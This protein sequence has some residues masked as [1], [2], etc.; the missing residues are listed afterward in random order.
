LKQARRSFYTICESPCD[1]VVAAG[2]QY[3]VSGD[4][5]RPSRR[6]ALP[7]GAHRDTIVV[8]P[9]SSLA[10][11]AGI[12]LTAVGVAAAVLGALRLVLSGFAENPDGSSNE[13]GR[14][15]TL[16][17]MLGGMAGVGGGVALIVLNASTKVSQTG[18]PTAGIADRLLRATAWRGDRPVQRLSPS[19]LSV[20]L[21]QGTF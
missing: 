14:N 1:T 2:G 6:F 21:V 10:F 11:G 12:V 16:G 19:T 17:I 5:T 7:E 18:D 15:A 4:A 3:R 13:A 8:K 20:Q 9:A